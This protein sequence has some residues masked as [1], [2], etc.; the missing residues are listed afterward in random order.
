MKIKKGDNVLIISGKDR[1]KT[2]KVLRAFPKEAKVLVENV[3]L[4][5][6]HKR[7]G[8]AGEKGQVLQLPVPFSVANVKLVCLKCGKPS[9]VGYKITDGKKV[10]VCKQCGGET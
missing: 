7:P 5:K 4:R 10:R 6:K 8:R 2:A 9:R 1:G 3:N